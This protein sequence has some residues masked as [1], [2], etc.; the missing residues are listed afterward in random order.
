M[1]RVK[2]RVDGRWLLAMG[3]WS[4]LPRE[5]LDAVD[6]HLKSHDNFLK[7]ELVP[8]VY[9]RILTSQKCVYPTIYMERNLIY[10]HESCLKVLLL[11]GYI[12]PINPAMR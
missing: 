7:L 4:E 2:A 3:Q 11:T 10:L 8:F 1:A 5:L 6:G 12:F 9:I